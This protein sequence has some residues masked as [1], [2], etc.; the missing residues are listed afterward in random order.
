M[1]TSPMTTARP[2]PCRLSWISSVLASPALQKLANRGVPAEVT[3]AFDRKQ[4]LLV[5]IYGDSRLSMLIGNVVQGVFSF[6]RR[7]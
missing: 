2:R 3:L 5:R 6:S 4:P 1:H 7:D